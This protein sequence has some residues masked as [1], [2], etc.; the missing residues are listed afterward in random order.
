MAL[1]QRQSGRPNVEG[2]MGAHPAADDMVRI[3]VSADQ[4]ETLLLFGAPLRCLAVEEVGVDPTI[5]LVDV[6]CINTVLQ[7][8]VLGLNPSDRVFVVLLLVAVTDPQGL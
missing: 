7:T 4:L 1:G 2:V 6:H 5:E 3:L 8:I